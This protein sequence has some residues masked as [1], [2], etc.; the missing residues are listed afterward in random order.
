LHI[1][2]EVIFTVV[3]LNFD[4]IS[5]ELQKE[6]RMC[7]LHHVNIV[8]LLAIVFEVGH[9]GLVMEFVLHGALDDFLF[10]YIV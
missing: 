6:A 3:F 8:A 5:Y 10:N 7:L 9:F 2:N 1:G 4:R